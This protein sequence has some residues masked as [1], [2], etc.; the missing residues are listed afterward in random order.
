MGLTWSNLANSKLKP[1][2]RRPE[3]L[4]CT[5]NGFGGQGSPTHKYIQEIF[6][7]TIKVT[8]KKN[9][10]LCRTYCLLR[11]FNTLR[12]KCNLIKVEC[13]IVKHITLTFIPVYKI[14]ENHGREKNNFQNILSRI[15]LVSN[16]QIRYCND[17]IISSMRMINFGVQIKQTLVLW[18]LTLFMGILNTKKKGVL[19]DW[20]SPVHATSKMDT[21]AAFQ[22]EIPHPLGKGQWSNQHATIRKDIKIS[23]GY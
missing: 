23:I 17:V 6:R 21:R 18:I 15:L 22:G 16:S 11:I 7:A 10:T 1:P 14:L 8:R 20:K 3:S 13:L 12:S 2:N 19:I 4:R 5:N 9:S